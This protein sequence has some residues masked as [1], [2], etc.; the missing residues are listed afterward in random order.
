MNFF[1]S[2]NPGIDG[3]NELT[4]AEAIVVQ[5]IA[6]LGDPNADRILFW[7]DS[8]GSYQHLSVGSGLSI[9]GTT[10]SASGGGTIDGSGTTNEIVYWVDSDTVGALAVATYPS[11]TELARVKGVTSGIQTQ[12]D[13]K[14]STATAA[15][16]YQPLDSDLTTI[17]GLTAT[18][19]NFIVSVSSAWASS[20]R[21]NACNGVSPSS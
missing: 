5:Q 8:A 20:A 15:A 10:L 1:D 14:L 19:D 7:D 21:W 9:A 4:D 2:Q 17:S 11:L 6:G 12:L 16:T 13:A 3:L 18:T